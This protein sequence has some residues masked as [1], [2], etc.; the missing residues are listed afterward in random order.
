MSLMGRKEKM[1]KKRI[2]QA[3]KVENTNKKKEKYKEIDG[4][5]YK[6]KKP[7]MLPSRQI[8]L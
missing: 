7:S 1:K 3:E 6:K 4:K 8:F 2:I 5:M